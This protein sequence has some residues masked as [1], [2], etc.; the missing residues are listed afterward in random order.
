MRSAREAL[1]V[2]R[3]T[4]QRLEQVR[5]LLALSRLSRR[6]GQSEAAGRDWQAAVAIAA[7]IGMPEPAEPARR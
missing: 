1:A 4:G 5:A 2:S 3:D 6:A 7:E